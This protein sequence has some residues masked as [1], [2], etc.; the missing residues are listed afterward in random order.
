MSRKRIV[1]VNQ[2]GENRGD[3]AAMR[4]MVRGLNAAL[5]GDVDFDIVFQC[6]DRS[7]VISF[8]LPVRVHHMVMPIYD[9]A[10]LT[11][12]A[13]VKTTGLEAGFLL[14][15]GT[16]EIVA[17]ISRADLL[18]SAP[19]GPYFGDIYSLHEP[20]HWLYVW[21]GRLYDKPCFL[22]APS[23]GPFKKVGHNWFR[24]KVFGMFNDICVREVQ[25]LSYLREL[26]SPDFEIHLTADSAIQETIEPFDR[27]AYFAG[28]R[29]AL[30]DKFIVAVTAMQYRYPGDP[31]PAWQRAH[32]TEV[33]LTSLSHLAQRHDCHF[34]FLPQ[35]YGKVHND[36]LYHE[37][38]GKRLPTGTSWEIVP[39]NFDSDR[40]RKVFGMVDLCLA[41][42][43]H[44]QIFATTS[45]VPGVFL[46]YE[47]K[48]FAYLEAIGMREFALDIRKVDKNTLCTKLDEVID[49][50][51]ELAVLLVQNA[52]FLREKSQESTRLAARLL[53]K[54]GSQ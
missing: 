14:T 22:Y 46:C 39:A 37:L 5:G 6:R 9:I 32:F 53:R 13:V 45:G 7:L 40:H 27:C 15:A 29:A 34:I 30:A 50:R 42:R 10:L 43:Y 1:V 28:D 26:I 36:T 4:A 52:A 24:R 3:E 2:H 19:G 51:K 47:H 48:Q 23:V 25:S 11:L 41:S 31:D 8:E 21:L 20:V 18:V 16:R 54:D 12:Y 44:P 35:L 38:L 17:A 33:F 49:R